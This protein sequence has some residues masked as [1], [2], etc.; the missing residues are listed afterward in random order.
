MLH[1]VYPLQQMQDHRVLEA[2]GRVRLKSCSGLSVRKQH[3]VQF[4]L[5]Y[6]SFAIVM[7]ALTE[8][9]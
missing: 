2:S 8:P 3:L 4:C 5:V 1:L 9:S 7:T 6:F